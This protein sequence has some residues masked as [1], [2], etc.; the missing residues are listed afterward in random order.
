[1]DELF[2][3]RENFKCIVFVV[4]LNDIILYILELLLVETLESLFSTN[5]SH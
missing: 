2:D 5:L 4:D 3:L 1:M